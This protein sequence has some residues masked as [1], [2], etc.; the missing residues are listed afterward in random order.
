[1]TK[2]THR[3]YSICFAFVGAILLD[4][5]RI[6]PINYYITIPILLMAS[7]YG[8]LMPDVDHDWKNVAEKTT[9]N[10]II[11]KLIHMTGGK[12]RSWQTHSLDICLGF[13]AASWIVPKALWI[14]GVF[15]D[16]D[17]ELARL[18]LIGVSLGWLSHLFSDSLTSGGI[19]ISFLSKKKVALVPKQLFGLKFNTGN[20]WEDFNY[21]V[22]RVINNILGVICVMYPLRDFIVE[23]FTL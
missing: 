11:N 15:N 9:S 22:M 3:Q 13:T 2:K 19:R 4:M 8:A 20:E 14:S 21:S 23:L 6:T 10:F 12:H 5:H 1:M 17:L 16:V 18:L 7:R